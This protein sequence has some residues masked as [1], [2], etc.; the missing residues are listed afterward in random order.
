MQSIGQPTK[1]VMLPKGGEKCC[2]TDMEAH[3]SDLMS[4]RGVEADTSKRK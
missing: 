4:T 1:V 2:I 3:F